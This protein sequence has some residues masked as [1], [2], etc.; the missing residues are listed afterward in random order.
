MRLLLDTHVFL[1]LIGSGSA[2]LPA[3]VVALLEDG[4]AEHSSE[5]REPV[6]DRDQV[7]AGQAQAGGRTRRL[8]RPSSRPRRRDRADRRAPCARARRARAD[9]PR[10]VRP[11]AARA[12]SGRGTAAPHHRPRPC[13]ASAGGEGIGSGFDQFGPHPTKGFKTVRPVRR[14]WSRQRHGEAPAP[15]ASVSTLTFVAP[16]RPFRGCR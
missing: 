1:A 12:M 2:D 14:A 15:P 13:R 8:A 7:P 6:G 4:D 11:D 5:R 3:T 16:E 10:S 9:D